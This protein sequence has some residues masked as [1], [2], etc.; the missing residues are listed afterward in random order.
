M[1]L[2]LYIQKLRCRDIKFLTK[3]AELWVQSPGAFLWETRPHV[4][5][6]SPACKKLRSSEERITKPKEK[7]NHKSESVAPKEH[8]QG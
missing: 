7:W 6:H 5:E 4:Q 8:P 1:T 2:T 3:E